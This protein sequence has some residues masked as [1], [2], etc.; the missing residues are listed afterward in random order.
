MMANK[1]IF[2]VITAYYQEPLE[3]IQRAI[4]SVKNMDPGS[5]EVRHYLIA[6]G[7]P[8][9][10]LINQ[11]KFHFILNQSH[12]DFGDTPRLVGSMIAIREGVTGLMFLDADNIVYSNHLRLASGKYI[13]DQTN[14]ILT[15]RDWLRLDGTRL[16]YISNEDENYS[17][18]DTG[19]FTF[20]DEAI[21]EVLKWALI[22]KELSSFGDRYFWNLLKSL[23]KEYGATEV[24]T[25]GYTCLWKDVYISLGE[26]P[27]IESLNKKF[28]YLADKQ[29]F[30]SLSESKLKN[31]LK[32]LRI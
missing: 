2:A 30:A 25:I 10:E 24:S 11:H 32:R 17:H 26:N 12:S 14:I 31:L 6:D 16:D 5:Y 8:Q 13:N 4:S 21:F 9:T 23:R 22:P 1:P 20:F 28:N 19:C 27:P 18:V 15:K 7:H 29:Y 3:I